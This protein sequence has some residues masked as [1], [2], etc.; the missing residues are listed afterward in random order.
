MARKKRNGQTQTPVNGVVQSSLPFMP[1]ADER[2]DIST[3]ETWLWDAACAI[4]GATDAPKFKDF[5]LPLVFYKRLSDVFKDEVADYAAGSISEDEAMWEIED[6]H[7]DALKTGR[8]PI[9][10]FYIPPAYSWDKIRNHGADGHL[11]EFVT[12]AMREVA[13]QNPLLDGVLN[14]KDFNERQSGQ[15]T[16]DEEHLASL[17]EVVSRHRL[18]LK[19]TEPD[20]LGRAYEYLLRKFAEGQGQSA[21]EFYTPKEVGWLMAELISAGPHSTVYDPTCGSGGLLIKARLLFEKQHPEWTT[22]APKLFGQE[23]NPVTFAISKMNMFL[24]DYTDSTFAIGDTFR[25]PGFTEGNKL[26][27]FDYIVANP[28]WNQDNY[29][30]AFYD[31]DTWERFNYGKPTKSSADWGW[32]QHMFAS[33]N[34]GGRAAI[35]LDSGAVSRGSGSKSSNREREIRKEFVERD[36]IEGVVLLPENLFYNTTA[37]GIILLLNQSKPEN[38]RQQ[39]LLINAS[40]YFIKEKPKNVLSDEGIAAVSEVYRNWETR[41]KLSRVVTLD[42]IR[43]A[44]YNLSSSQFVD[45][46]DKAKYRPISEI[47]TDLR[48]ASKEREKADEELSKLLLRLGMNNEIA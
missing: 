36:F 19:N 18:G 15:R 41:E 2:L 25:R 1:S 9:V 17:I 37:P 46:N 27:R 26:Q 6:D 33:L 42:E 7:A 35:V 32:V 47:L 20:I 31:N 23:L 3:L 40:A 21:G 28:M 45:I 43:S 38:R 34:D 48:I 30:D 16:L 22:K 29:D 44:D 10:R 13:R 4:R 12:D 24:H 14:I 5:I 39:F 11:G 8:P